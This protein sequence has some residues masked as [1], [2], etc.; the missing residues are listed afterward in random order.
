MRRLSNGV[1][2]GCRLTRFPLRNV[3]DRD[4]TGD[5]LNAI[6]TRLASSATG[7]SSTEN[8]PTLREALSRR[9]K[10]SPSTNVDDD[11]VPASSA[12]EPCESTSLLDSPVTDHTLLDDAFTYFPPL[13]DP[14]VQYVPGKQLID[15]GYVRYRV[16]VQYQGGDF[17]GWKKTTEKRRKTSALEDHEA[18]EVLPRAKTVLED[19]LAV[20][21]DIDRVNVFEGA[22]LETGVSAR[23][24]TCHVDI[25]ASVQLMPRTILQRASVWL[26]K[27]KSPMAILSCHPCKNQ[28]FHAR[29]SGSRRVYAYRILNRIAPPLFD[30]GLQ[31]HVDGYLDTHRMAAYAKRLEGT[32]DYGF[33]CDAKMA[34]TLRKESSVS[35]EN[36]LMKPPHKVHTFVDESMET[37]HPAT[38]AARTAARSEGVTSLGTVR[39]VE[40][41]KVVRQEDEVIIWFVGKSFLRHQVRSMVSALKL[42]GEGLWGEREIEFALQRGFEPSRTKA[43]RE[44]PAPA[45]VHGL[46]LW[47]IEYPPEHRDDYIPYVDSGIVEGMDVAQTL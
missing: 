30:A 11:D 7:K 41:I 16:D 18:P 17:D 5:V 6:K 34:H 10:T 40:H 2:A 1:F 8:G 20:A 44:R 4:G 45:P 25:P 42:V 43:R 21:L 12:L 14:A 46:V 23:R 28:Q 47:E 32:M 29:Y 27:K 19:A 26:E 31:W 35:K 9:M 15:P 22:V 37:L 13:V 24:L 38:I 3:H 33:F 36:D 39:T